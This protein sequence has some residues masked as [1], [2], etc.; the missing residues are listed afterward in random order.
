MDEMPNRKHTNIIS[1]T[2]RSEF[3]EGDE[4]VPEE[5]ICQSTLGAFRHLGEEVK[6]ADITERNGSTG[7]HP[8]GWL[9]LSIGAIR[10]PYKD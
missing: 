6:L 1:I 5:D 7:S 8:V 2:L 3:R 4:V 10:I 9:A